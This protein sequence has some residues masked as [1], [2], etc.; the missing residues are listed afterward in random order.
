MKIINEIGALEAFDKKLGIA[1][2]NFDGFHLGHQKIVNTMLNHC[3]KYNML[4]MIMLFVP[5]P[6]IALKGEKRFLINNY[7]HRRKFMEESGLDVLFEVDFVPE[8]SDL[9]PAKFLDKYILSKYNIGR[10][11]LGHNF[12]FGKDKKGGR[13]LLEKHCRKNNIFVD[14][15]DE[16]TECGEKI[17]SSQI[18]NLLKQGNVDKSNKLL[19]RE[20]F[21][22]GS[23]IHGFGRG[24]GMG[25]PTVNL[26]LKEDMLIPASGVYCTKVIHN[27]NVYPSLTNIG[28]NPTF[29]RSGELTIETHILDFWGNIYGDEIRI[30]FMEKIREEKRFQ[31]SDEL[32]EQIKRDIEARRNKDF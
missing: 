31:S 10:F 32:K 26:D 5:H 16:F 27:D 24:K 6:R 1:I 18:R 22:E 3:K 12:S 8:F 20:F 25:F 23:V 4:L 13:V 21:L 7:K 17:S 30:C 2:G 15:L 9:S 19:G 29:Q 28:F 11:F 14:I